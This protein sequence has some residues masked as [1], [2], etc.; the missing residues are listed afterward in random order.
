[1]S[2]QNKR[3]PLSTVFKS[4]QDSSLEAYEQQKENW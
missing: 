1:M 2:Y 4:L 3:T